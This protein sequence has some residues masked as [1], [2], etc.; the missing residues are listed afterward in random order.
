MITDPAVIELLQTIADRLQM[1]LE[2]FGWV[3][4]F[5]AAGI[6]AVTWKG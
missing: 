4:G 1:I 6:I 2:A 5:I 3:G